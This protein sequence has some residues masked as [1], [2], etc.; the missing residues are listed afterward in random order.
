M[1]AVVPLLHYRKV[2][3]SPII[4][5]FYTYSSI[6]T[7]LQKILKEA[8]VLILDD[9]KRTKVPTHS[10]RHSCAA[11]LLAN[12]ASIEQVSHYLGHKSIQVTIESYGHLTK[13]ALKGMGNLLSDVISA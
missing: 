1:D 10:F 12:G 11:N 3:S 6:R 4:G 9:P 5:N 8:G 7:Q 2:D 13:D